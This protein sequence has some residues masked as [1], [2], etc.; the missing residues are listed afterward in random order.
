[1]T[2]LL[3]L[4][5]AALIY[6]IQARLY[7]RHWN[8]GLSVA[9]HFSKQAV[10]EGET[11]AL[12]EEITNNKRL[13]LPILHV[14]FQISR[15]LL[16]E[17]GENTAVSDQSYR[18]DIFSILFYQKITR[19]L[20]FQCTK[21]G[22]YTIDQANLVSS[23]LFLS[24]NLVDN[25]KQRTHIYVYPREI[26]ISAMEIPFQKAMGTLVNRRLLFEDPFEF[27]GIREYQITDPMNAIN[28]KAT[29]KTGDL[30][31]NVYHSTLTP[32]AVILLDLKDDTLWRY[33]D[34]HEVGIRIAAALAIRFLV[35]SIPTRIICNGRDQITKE[36]VR[37]PAGNGKRQIAAI[38]ESLARIDLSLDPV[39]CTDQMRQEISDQAGNKNHA[40]YIFISSSFGHQRD[41]LL[42]RLA[43]LGSGAMWVA[44]HEKEMAVP[45]SSSD[46]LNVVTWEVQRNEV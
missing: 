19:T 31:V 33:D 10:L 40:Y 43:D 32:E 4:L 8:R 13:P 37:V 5:G 18:H 34:L 25:Q 30:M 23:N 20:K 14:K 28:W 15:N 11:A 35:Q 44:L 27:R 45:V 12:V 29:A 7:S 1:M 42:K 41:V 21:R 36:I 6:L 46:N 24:G 22:F 17:G 26:N 9:I 2:I 16:F 38:N 3:L 39:S